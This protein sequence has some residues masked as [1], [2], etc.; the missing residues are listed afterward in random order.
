MEDYAE[1]VRQIGDTARQLISDG[2]PESEAIGV[3]IGQDDKL[4]AGLKDLATEQRAKLDDALK[5]FMLNR[6]VDD[7]EQWI[8]E[9][10]CCWI[11]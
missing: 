9:R 8:A 4:Y 7:L 6:E 11:T 3:G 10:G 1:T 5:L 2:H